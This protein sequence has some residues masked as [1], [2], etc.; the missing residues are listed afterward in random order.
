MNIYLSALQRYGGEQASLQWRNAS[1]GV[2]TRSADT[3]AIRFARQPQESQDR[4]QRL[5]MQLAE[6]L[7]LDSFTILQKLERGVNNQIRALREQGQLE[8]IKNEIQIPWDIEKALT[9]EFLGYALEVNIHDK[10]A[11]IMVESLAKTYTEDE[12]ERAL[13]LFE[14]PETMTLERHP[15]YVKLWDEFLKGYF[16]HLF[17]EEP[18]DLGFAW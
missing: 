1:M 14:E 5:A 17:G 12:L 4:K 9:R 11:Q 16:R 6:H 10:A 18:G 13:K 3:V 15:E 7:G 8:T 2:Q